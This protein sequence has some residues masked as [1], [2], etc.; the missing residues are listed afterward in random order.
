M[1]L[2]HPTSSS[3]AG[4]EKLIKGIKNKGYDIGTVTELMD[5]KRLITKTR[6]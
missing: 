4:L 3:A 5:E 1:I 2:M 6:K